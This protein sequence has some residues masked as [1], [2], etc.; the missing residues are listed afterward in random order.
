MDDDYF[1]DAFDC[2]FSVNASV[3]GGYVR[4]VDFYYY[5]EVNSTAVLIWSDPPP[6]LSNLTVTSQKSGIWLVGSSLKAYL[7]TVGIGNPSGIYSQGCFIW[8]LFDY[9][10]HD[11]KVNVE[12]LY[13]T[14]STYR[15]IVIPI[16]MQTYV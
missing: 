16:I 9:E 6:K 14:G 7:K 11:L 2:S 5:G 12:L 13:W 3:E 8:M 1:G 15:K 4:S 10:R